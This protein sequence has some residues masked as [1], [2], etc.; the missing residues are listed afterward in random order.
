MYGLLITLAIIDGLLLMVVVLLQAAK[1]EGL[2]GIAG[3]ASSSMSSTFGTRRTADFLSKA[4]WWLGGGLLVISLA[5]NLFFL[6]GKTTSA[7]RDSIIQNSRNQSAV[8]TQP[9]M[10]NPVTTPPT[11]SGNNTQPKGK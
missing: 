5:I 1:G 4:S 9:A 10:P 11:T 3:G 2:A 8:P 6:P 7:E